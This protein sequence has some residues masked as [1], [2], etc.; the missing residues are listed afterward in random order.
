MS[1]C[2]ANTQRWGP[3][4]GA[5]ESK[6]NVKSLGKDGKF[7]WVC[8]IPVLEKFNLLMKSHCL[9]KHCVFVKLIQLSVQQGEHCLG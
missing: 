8:Y 3:W 1:V 4:F 9:Y 2:Q 5:D 6:I 7:N